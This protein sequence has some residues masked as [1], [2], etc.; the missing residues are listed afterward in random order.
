MDA[1]YAIM[2]LVL[3]AVIYSAVM[4]GVSRFGHGKYDWRKINR[5]TKICHWL[6]LCFILAFLMMVIYFIPP[7]VC[8]EHF[9]YKVGAPIV[10]ALLIIFFVGFLAF[11]SVGGSMGTIAGALY[12]IIMIIAPIAMWIFMSMEMLMNIIKKVSC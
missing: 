7:S 2:V 6:L 9:I 11:F 10:P 12:F 5:E 4:Y 3:D 8:I 1:W